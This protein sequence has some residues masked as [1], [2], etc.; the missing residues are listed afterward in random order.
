MIQGWCLSPA[1]IHVQGASGS[2]IVLPCVPAARPL[3]VT[4]DR[5]RR[6]DDDPRPACTCVQKCQC[7]CGLEDP[8][9]G[10]R[11]CAEARLYLRLF[12]N[13]SGRVERIVG[14][15][16]SKSRAPVLL[17]GSVIKPLGGVVSHP[18]LRPRSP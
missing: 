3:R 12:L 16:W 17:P 18:V 1:R 9:G 5:L 10:G 15:H 14:H 11:V 13:F 8:V 7:H 2:W 6:Q 4:G